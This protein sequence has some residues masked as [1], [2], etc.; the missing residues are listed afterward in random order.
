MYLKGQCREIFCLWFFHRTTSWSQ[1]GMFRNDFKLFL[2]F[3]ELFV[4]VVDSPVMNTP[5][6]AFCKAFFSNISHMS[7]SSLSNLQSI[8]KWK[9]PLNVVVCSLKSVKRLPGVQNDFSVINTLGTLDSP[10]MNTPGGFDLPVL[11]TPESL[12]STVMNTP[13]S[14]LLSV[15]GTSIRKG[16][17][18]KRL[19]TNSPG[20][21][22]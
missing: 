9:V 5:G 7:L 19:I 8:S 22:E 2:I 21:R 6:S 10:V 3:V 13:G 20:T 4:F 1:I 14:Q 18:K 16:L 12:D 17:Q 11:N 15:F